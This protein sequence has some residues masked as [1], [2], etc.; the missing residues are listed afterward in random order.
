M[1]WISRIL[2]LYY[3]ES[4]YPAIWHHLPPISFFLLCRCPSFVL[5]HFF[6]GYLA[7][8]LR[9]ESKLYSLW[10]KTNFASLCKGLVVVGSE[11]F[12]RRQDC[13]GQSLL[14]SPI[15]RCWG[16]SVII[17]AS[18]RRRTT[19]LPTHPPGFKYWPKQKRRIFSLKSLYIVH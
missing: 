11:K 10:S 1:E 3:G 8:Q 13:V 14:M 18:S 16:M 15:H 5:L 12:F 17:G 19:Y 2:V 9:C 7:E 4:A 6:A